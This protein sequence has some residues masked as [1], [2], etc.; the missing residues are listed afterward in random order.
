M[1]SKNGK[2]TPIMINEYCKYMG[3]V[4]RFSYHIL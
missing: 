2:S 1:I 3:G 4:D